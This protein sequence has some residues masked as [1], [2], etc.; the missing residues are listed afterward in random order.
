[1]KKDKIILNNLENPKINNSPNIYN[2]SNKKT[3][4]NSY[5]NKIPILNLSKQKET[6]NNPIKLYEP[7]IEPKIETNTISQTIP[8]AIDYVYDQTT[9][10]VNQKSSSN[11]KIKI[12]FKEKQFQPINLKSKEIIKGN[13]NGFLSGL[14]AW[15]TQSRDNEESFIDVESLDVDLDNPTKSLKHKTSN[16]KTSW[17]K[18]KEYNTNQ[19]KEYKDKTIKAKRPFT[20]NVMAKSQSN[21]HIAS[22]P[23]PTKQRKII[24]AKN[25]KTTVVQKPYEDMLEKFTLKNNSIKEKLNSTFSCSD[26]KSPCNEDPFVRDKNNNLV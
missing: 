16:T 26:L 5:L 22:N 17:N 3:Q 15:H 13:R 1:V 2:E 4:S 18:A 10:L 11:A 25:N 24:S 14:S 12:W 6:S 20:C 7:K 8:I 21:K 19:V 23:I 9:A